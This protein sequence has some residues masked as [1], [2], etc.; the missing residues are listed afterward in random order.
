MR[1]DNARR[2]ATCAFLVGAIALV[3]VR[4]SADDTSSKAQV[5]TEAVAP[6]MT[7][8]PP[9]RLP[10]YVTGAIAIVAAGA[11]GVLGLKALSQASDFKRT[12]TE[13][14]ADSGGTT[15]LGADILFGVALTFAVTSVTLLFMGDQTSP[16]PGK[17]SLGDRVLSEMRASNGTATAGVRF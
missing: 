6:P 9:D 17:K 11:G 13:D 2:L 4:A 5:D 7:V 15:A 1:F 16:A 10:V 12:P 3:S 8:A 14:L